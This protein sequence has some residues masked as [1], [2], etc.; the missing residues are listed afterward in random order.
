MSLVVEAI[1]VLEQDERK[2]ED[3]QKKSIILKQ[4]KRN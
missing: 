2:E 3:L 4:E 1:T